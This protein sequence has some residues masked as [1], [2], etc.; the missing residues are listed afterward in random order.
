MRVVAGRGSKVRQATLDRIWNG[1]VLSQPTDFMDLVRQAAQEVRRA[2][3]W[4]D[5]TGKQDEA[6]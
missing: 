3:A 5:R 2:Q 6:A 1:A 4:Q